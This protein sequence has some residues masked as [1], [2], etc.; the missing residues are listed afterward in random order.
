MGRVAE[1]GSL[2]G[3]AYIKQPNTNKGIT[4]KKQIRMVAESCLLAFVVGCSS[5]QEHH[6]PAAAAAVGSDQQSKTHNAQLQTDAD[7]AEIAQLRKDADK[8]DATAQYLLGMRYAKGE[9]VT[10]DRIEAYKW[11]HI[12]VERGNA[13]AA[14]PRYE[15]E[16]LMTGSEYLKARERAVKIL[17]TMPANEYLEARERA[18]KIL[19]TM[20]ATELKNAN[21]PRGEWSKDF[22]VLVDELTT[23]APKTRGQISDAY[24]QEYKDKPITWKFA[25]KEVTQQGNKTTLIFDLEPFGI[26]QRFFL[27]RPV[28]AGFEAAADSID[29]WKKVT[30]GSQV[31]VSGTL[32]GVFFANMTPGN[33]DRSVD[34]AVVSVEG[35]KVIRD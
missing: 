21:A 2:G 26:R 17:T 13:K 25:F 5:T 3:V 29:D 19:T 12:A 11:L 33:S 9:R 27:G 20:P 18:V 23:L 14:S 30:P 8:G 24:G 4:M 10:V 32:K 6:A 35:V 34:V 1:L 31:S 22:G 15:V 7:K 28:M 16:A